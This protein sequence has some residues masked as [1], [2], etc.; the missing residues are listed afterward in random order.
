M[1]INLTDAAIDFFKNDMAVPDD[2]GVQIKG[3]TY[4]N[5]NVHENFSVAI[6]VSTPSSTPFA[7]VEEDGLTVFV[8][9]SDSWF[10]NGFDLDIDYDTAEGVP[11][12]FFRSNDGSDLDSISSP[13]K[14]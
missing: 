9:Q 3:K 12:Y 8:E 4:G 5:T 13:S 14:N 1:E 10:V 11:T 6:T 7:L 2:K